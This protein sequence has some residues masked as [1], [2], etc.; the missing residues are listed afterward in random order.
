MGLA[1][2]T[3]LG[4]YE[5]REQI[6]AGGMGE[7]YRGYDTKL[8][9]D[10][11][12]K[13]LPE[14][15]SRDSERL[16]RFR[17]EATMLASL[18]H[19][20]IATIHG[21]EESGAQPCLVME[22]VPGDTLA[23]RVALGPLSAR[24][25]LRVGQQ[26]AEAL[27]HAHRKGISHRDIK[28]A[29]IKVTPDGNV[30]VLDFGL[31]K[32][33]ADEGVNPDDVPTLSAM[34][35]EDGRILGTPPYMSP[36]QAQGKQVDKQT[37]IWAFG[38]VLYELLTAKR[39]FPGENTTQTIA[40]VLRNEPDW[41][42]L[43]AD[44]PATV[45]TLL[46]RCLQKDQ[47]RRLH[48]AADLAIEI[49][50]SLAGA[51][52][53]P[54]VEATGSSHPLTRQRV[55]P[56]VVA[57]VAIL[58]ALTLAVPYFRSPSEESRTIQFS[59]TLPSELAVLGATLAVSPD[60]SQ[61]AFAAADASTG[62]SLIWVRPLNSSSAL[63]VP[64][65]E[66]VGNTLFWSPDSRFL[67]FVADGKLKTVPASG[68]SAQVLTEAFP[69]GGSWSRD[70]TILFTPTLYS[71][72]AQIPAAGGA[73]SLVTTPDASR[74]ERAHRHPQFLPDGRRFLY[75]NL[76]GIYAGSL[77]SPETR[78]VLRAQVKAEYAASGYLFFIQDRALMAQPFDVESLELSGQPSMVAD[79]LNLNIQ[80]NSASFSVSG[81]GVLAYGTGSP[82]Y[83]GLSWFDRTGR[84]IGTIQAPGASAG[85]ELSPDGRTLA[86]EVGGGQMTNDIWLFD[87]ARGVSTRFTSDP[88]W[89]RFARW[90]PD[91]SRVLFHSDRVSA[92]D[93]YQKRSSGAGE[94]GILLQDPQRKYPY[95]WSSDGRYVVYAVFGSTQGQTADLWVLPL[96]GDR[97]PFPFLA[98]RF[99]ENHARFS[100]DVRWMAFV[101]N[102]SGRDE[103]YVSSFPSGGNKVRVSTN[104]GVQP[105]WR[106]DGKELFYLS[107]DRKMMAV[108]VQLGSTI[109]VGAPQALFG[110]SIAPRGSGQPWAFYQYDATADGQRFLVFAPA[111]DATVPITVVL[112]WMAGLKKQ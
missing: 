97:E 2:G 22:F 47:G 29:N 90:S 102:E 108:P 98:T 103:V 9:R 30:K 65:T 50:E 31:A 28:P 3:R 105:R 67:G 49:E 71:G 17:R 45:R 11:A 12:L 59:I 38:C 78:Q 53:G 13:V 41:Q 56:W 72:L 5:V 70:G 66:G 39:A 27:E 89:E 92:Y 74:G 79:G 44:T 20:N 112:N 18:N 73:P 64:G 40:A 26:I 6:G 60:G 86:L 110:I 7:V 81:R 10:I 93:L 83:E 77:D 57:A 19:A 4:Q 82:E 69:R 80:A 62:N 84:Q 94:E 37:D 46:R 35:T 101:S 100:P 106:R 14:Q 99:Q 52:L 15:F 43:P 55:L 107:P 96:F 32:A 87:I 24:E 42:K 48:S 95:D 34:P 76:N 75:T 16:A 91:G 58:L 36:E 109:E 33:L 23:E 1:A 63:P 51:A 85:P 88:G 61:V 21:L 111:E 25:A 104:G 8:K 68:G 54:A